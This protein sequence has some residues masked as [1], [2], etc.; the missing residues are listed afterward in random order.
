MGTQSIGLKIAG[1]WKPS[2]WKL[3]DA[4]HVKRIALKTPINDFQ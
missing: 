1:Q 2:Q 3:S 4:A